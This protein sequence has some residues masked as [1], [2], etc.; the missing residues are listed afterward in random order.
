MTN[1]NTYTVVGGHRVQGHRVQNGR[2][3]K[4][5]GGSH[6]GHGRFLDNF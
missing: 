5:F 4:S 6:K 3:A 2:F 1:K